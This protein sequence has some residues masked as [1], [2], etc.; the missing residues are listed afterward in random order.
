MRYKIMEKKG[1]RNSMFP[2]LNSNPLTLEKGTKISHMKFSLDSRKL[3]FSAAQ[4]KHVPRMFLSIE[5][6]KHEENDTRRSIKIVRR[7]DMNGESHNS[8][9]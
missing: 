9:W 7:L 1:P 4:K 5:I 8:L 3:Q 2:P 6:L